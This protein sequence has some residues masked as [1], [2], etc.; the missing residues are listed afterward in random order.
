M[1]EGLAHGDPATGQVVGH[2][3]ALSLNGARGADPAMRTGQ[4]EGP[5]V[6]FLGRGAGDGGGT[7]DDEECGHDVLLCACGLVLCLV[8]PMEGLALRMG[9]EVF[10]EVNQEKRV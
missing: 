9:S 10:A 6:G 8:D 3:P 7:G 2:N 1:W 4:R 5:G